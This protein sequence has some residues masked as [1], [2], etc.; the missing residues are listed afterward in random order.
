MGRNG[1]CPPTLHFRNENLND[2]V[3]HVCGGVHKNKRL[4]GFIC[5]FF[6]T[7]HR[8]SGIVF[9]LANEI[10]VLKDQVFRTRI[11]FDG[12]T[13]PGD[14]RLAGE[15]GVDAIGFDF[16]PD[17]PCRLRVEEA[18]F[19]RNAL[20]PLMAGVAIFHDNNVDEARDI[21]RLLHP[22]LIEFRGEEDDA[23]MRSFGVPYARM[24]RRMEC[25]ETNGAA[26]HSRYPNAAVFVLH[27][28]EAGSDP[29]DW[30]WLPQGLGKPLMLTGGITSDNV[31]GI[32]ATFAPW[33]VST[34]ESIESAPGQVDGDSMKRFLHAARGA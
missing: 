20:A 29:G 28:G 12:L 1:T 4:T 15:L 14:V 21:V 3:M 22:A 26:I 13:R 7:T 2:S 8:Y 5:G 34:R 17:A 11:R 6:F 31:A 24:L 10:F 27:A 19:V 9:Q 16:S 32:I 25:E 33:G 18:R 23:R 30:S